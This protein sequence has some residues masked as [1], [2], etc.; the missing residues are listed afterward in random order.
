VVHIEHGFT[1]A[2][3]LEE[4]L[5]LDF[6]VGVGI[7]DFIKCKRDSDRK[8]AAVWL[9]GHG[10][11]VTENLRCSGVEDYLLDRVVLFELMECLQK[12][13]KDAPAYYCFLCDT[14]PSWTYF[15]GYFAVMDGNKR[16]VGMTLSGKRD[17]WLE[18]VVAPPCNEVEGVVVEGEEFEFFVVCDHVFVFSGRKD[19]LDF[20]RVKVDEPRTR[21]CMFA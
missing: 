19:K 3:R 16:R 7:G 11:K 10:E 18:F 9:G 5:D 17:I 12:G 8:R 4:T 2:P 6:D 20:V 1:Y 15:G 14:S 13:Q 21:F